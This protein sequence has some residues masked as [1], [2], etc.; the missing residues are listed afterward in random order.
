MRIGNT[1]LPLG[2]IL[3]PMAGY[4][5][6]AM[7]VLCRR[8]G[9]AYAVTEMVSAAALCYGDEKTAAL[10]ALTAD[11]GP[12][13]VQLFGHDPAEMRR[14]AAMVAAGRLPG[15]V[16]SCA[17]AAIDLNMGCPVKK[18]VSGGD[19]SALLRDVPLCARLT[20]A[21]AE[22]AAAYGVPV[23][24]KL[25][26]GWD[27]GSI[28]APEA[29]A[30]VAAAGA[31]AVCVHARTRAQMYAPGA[32]WSV[33]A[34]VREAVPPAIPVIG[35]GDVTDAASWRRMIAETGCDG[36]AVGRAAMGN[37]WVFSE[38]A[39]AASGAPFTPPDADARRA[40]AWELA[41][42]VVAAHGE[43]A[44]VRL[45]RGRIC[46]FLTGMR[47]AAQLR[48]RL[49]AAER[50]EEIREILLGGENFAGA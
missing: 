38:I 10:A 23:T 8:L 17:P 11:E 1:E 3:S 46:H 9:A 48:A 43:A 22:G 18:I 39:A 40:C 30:A 42:A 4:T 27:E 14:A 49:H 36:V 25:R 15:G 2:L 28:N 44:G 29:A 24:V 16:V 32:D 34:R 31:T 47:G 19:G 33:I 13:A 50:L 35:N 37:P 41:C 20:A 45:C 5:D 21:A 26:A 12:T 6:R 7:R